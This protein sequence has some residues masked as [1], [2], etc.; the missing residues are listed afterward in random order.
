MTRP[1]RSALAP[2]IALAAATLLAAGCLPIPHTA[3]IAPAIDGRFLDEGGRPVAGARVALSTESSDSTCAAPVSTTTTDAEGRFSFG[4]IRKR[5][6]YV[7]LIGDL[8]YP[9]RVCAGTGD[10]FNP[11]FSRLRAVRSPGH[12][13]LDCV[14][15]V[16][17]P[18][19][20]APLECVDRRRAP[21]AADRPR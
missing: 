11:G 3:T 2:S 6:R 10:V 16:M 1:T 19:Q 14:Q 5:E 7:L 12:E 9:Y 21:A 17:S 20:S 18:L 13:S 4:A 8:F 15:S